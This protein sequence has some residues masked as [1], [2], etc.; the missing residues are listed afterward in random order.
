MNYFAYGSNIN[1]NRMKRRVGDFL[2]PVIGK[3]NGYE[4]KF[5]KKSKDGSGKAN[6]VVNP[7]E[8]IEGRLFELTDKQLI[9]LESY[10]KGYH[11][12]D[13]QIN[14]EDKEISAITY[15]ADA[16]KIDNSLKPTEDYLDLIVCS[17]HEEPQLSD[18]HIEKINKGLND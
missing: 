14:V 1:F 10:E 15:V 16:N 4:L 2:E 7:E 8:V 5:N 6:I 11:R 3:L 18:E 17:A 12:E 9:K 13:V